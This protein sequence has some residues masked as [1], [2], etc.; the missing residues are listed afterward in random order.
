M[1]RASR[2]IGPQ[3][4]P[5]S[6]QRV[7]PRQ[8]SHALALLLTGRS[9]TADTAVDQFL[10]FARQQSLDLNDLWAVYDG[11]R[12][13]AATLI[14][15]SSG[16]TAMAFLSPLLDPAM[17]DPT[18]KLLAAACNTVDPKH[19]RL[20]QALLEPGQQLEQ[21][22][23]KAGGFTMLGHLVYMQRTVSGG[24][25]L[26]LPPQLQVI[27]YNQE[28]H[29]AFAEAIL[30]S[31]EQTQDCPGL[32]GLRHIDDIIAGHKAAGEFLPELWLAMF[33]KDEP[34]GV[35]LLNTLPHRDALELVYLGL[36]VPWRG[37]GLARHLVDHCLHLARKQQVSH[38]VLAVDE[39]NSSA[40]RLYRH[41]NFRTNTRK[42]AMICTVDP[43]IPPS[44]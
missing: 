28:N 34:V 19:I 38:I 35:M 18:S 11:Q 43:A 12:L 27:H 23:L 21:Q 10:D 29:H 40:I 30:A 5:L 16:R 9:T 37:Q 17:I 1:S 3:D 24:C 4:H 39:H 15:P 14:V 41:A 7:D 2:P 26:S 13:L 32:L 44:C 8:R 33:I 31:Y 22:A 36:S 42:T 25:Q 20:I 6:I